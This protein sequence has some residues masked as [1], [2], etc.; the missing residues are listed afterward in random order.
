MMKNK[1]QQMSTVKFHMVT[2]RCF[3]SKYDTEEEARAKATWYL[4][5]MRDNGYDMNIVKAWV[6]KVTTERLYEATL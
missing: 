3:H 2:E 4:E 6:E 5:Y 1:E